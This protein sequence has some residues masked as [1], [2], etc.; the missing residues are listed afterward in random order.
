MSTTATAAHYSIPKTVVADTEA[1][2]KGIR[3]NFS[4]G[5]ITGLTKR[6]SAL[7][8]R[9]LP[10]LDLEA[11]LMLAEN[12]LDEIRGMVDLLPQFVAQ[13]FSYEWVSGLFK[14]EHAC[15]SFCFDGE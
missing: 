12:G 6:R 14:T 2:L 7:L 4:S 13:Q 15:V 5:A 9:L 8:A 3:C 10:G 11:A 1:S